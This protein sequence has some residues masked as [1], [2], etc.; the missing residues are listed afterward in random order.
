MEWIALI[1]FILIFLLLLIFRIPAFKAMPI[2][3][4]ATLITAIYWGMTTSA[5]LASLSRTTLIFVEL[6]LL[7]LFAVT[8]LNTLIKQG[9]VEKIEKYLAS[10]STDRKVQAM[11]IAWAFVALIE[12]AA[13]FGTPAALAAPFLLAI[14][15]PAITAVTIS[16]I[17]DSTA[18]TF[19]AA[20]TPIIIGL[21]SSGLTP[22]EIMQSSIM[23]AGLHLILASVATIAIT[24][25]V[26][27]TKQEFFKFIPFAVFSALAFAVPYYLTARLVGPELPSI[28]GGVCAI[29]IISFAAQKGFLIEKTSTEKP[30]GTLKALTPF[31]F[32]ITAL[33]ISRNVEFIK[34]LL[35]LSGIGFTNMFG[36]GISQN[37]LVFYTPGFFFLL[38]IL[39]FST[40]KKESML[41][42]FNKI[43]FPMIAL[44]LILGVAQLLLYSN[45]NTLNLPSIPGYL[46][47]LLA[48]SGSYFTLLSP[49]I[50]YIGSFVA[51]S[52]TVSNILFS[53][54]QVDTAITL[55][56]STV[57]ITALQLIGSSAGNMVAVHNVITAAATLGLKHGEGKIIA[58]NLIV[59]LIYCML[60]GLIVF[61]F[62]I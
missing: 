22:L 33:I 54:L 9:N 58:N 12:G 36:T 40:T 43:K 60:A 17:G 4:L 50:G 11:L 61:L 26:A 27:K 16:L 31:I 19:G 34:K 46:A 23:A 29:I 35:Q 13:G 62:V 56:L 44:F 32:L 30:K 6:F 55:G 41:D 25:F 5:I 10:I 20:G 15:F 42:A 47:S 18:V 21:E 59:S 38:T 24:Y 14:G 53:S 37:L 51:G 39:I 2:I 45:L 3:F 48:G 52:S 8:L 49:L 7:I 28:I 57:A 1:P